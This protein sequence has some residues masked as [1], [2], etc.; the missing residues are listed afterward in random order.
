MLR[1]EDSISCRLIEL[2]ASGGTNPHLTLMHLLQ[3]CNIKYELRY[4]SLR[5]H[6]SMFQSSSVC[7][8]FHLLR[9]AL[10]RNSVYIVL[11]LKVT[12]ISVSRIIV[13]LA[14]KRQVKLNRY[15]LESIT[16]LKEIVLP[17]LST[18]SAQTRK[19]LATA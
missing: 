7:Q 2:M 8:V 13:E 18:H 12:F 14:T 11:H 4:E 17:V 3:L 15:V 1:S 9:D 16:T 19:S 10:I 6:V 5:Y